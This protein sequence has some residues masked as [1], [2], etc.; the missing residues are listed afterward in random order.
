MNEVNFVFYSGLFNNWQ[1]NLICIKIQIYCYNLLAMSKLM[2]KNAYTC[3]CILDTNEILED[4][5]NL[6]IVWNCQSSAEQGISS[7]DSN[8]D[9]FFSI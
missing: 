2:S 6:A 7:K 3:M 1:T 9:G 8:F 5:K 4:E